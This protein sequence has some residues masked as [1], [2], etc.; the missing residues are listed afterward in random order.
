M[1]RKNDCDMLCYGVMENFIGLKILYRICTTKKRAFE[2]VSGKAFIGK[3][4]RAFAKEY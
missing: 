2:N 4:H 1:L 3:F